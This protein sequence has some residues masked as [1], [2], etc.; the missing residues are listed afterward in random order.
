VKTLA[1]DTDKPDEHNSGHQDIQAEETANPVGK[2]LTD[3]QTEL[4][5]VLHDPRD[6][7]RIRESSSKDGEEQVN[8]FLFHGLVSC[9]LPLRRST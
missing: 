4:K 9:R 5:A 3:E 6:E 7:L 8:V 2:E 1:L